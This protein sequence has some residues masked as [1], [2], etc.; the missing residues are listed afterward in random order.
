MTPEERIAHQARIREFRDY[1]TCHAYQAEHHRQLAARARADT[2]LEQ[3]RQGS[4]DPPGQPSPA[5][6]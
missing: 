6:Q 4:L 5:R 2:L 1:D 3:Y